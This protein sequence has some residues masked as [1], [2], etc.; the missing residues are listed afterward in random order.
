[1]VK[2][3]SVDGFHRLMDDV[4]RGDKL[5]G[6]QLNVLLETYRREVAQLIDAEAVT[7]QEMVILQRYLTPAVPT[8][9][10]DDHLSGGES[11]IRQDGEGDG[12]D[13]VFAT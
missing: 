12:E 8:S 4:E 5:A 6:S 11:T 9:D 3:F 2:E 7:E 1:M 13:T 10:W